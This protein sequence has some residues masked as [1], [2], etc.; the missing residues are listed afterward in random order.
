MTDVRDGAFCLKGGTSDFRLPVYTSSRALLSVRFDEFRGELKRMATAVQV[1]ERDSPS[2]I[3]EAVFKYVRQ[4][5]DI[6][7]VLS[8]KSLIERGVLERRAV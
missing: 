4:F 5:P 6:N 2:A 8:H 7:W 3:L 1:S